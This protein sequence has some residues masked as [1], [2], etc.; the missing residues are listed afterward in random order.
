MV[1]KLKPCPFCGSDFLISQEPRDN[2]PVE[3]KFYIYHKYGELG[4]A[5][6]ECRLSVNG[7]FDSEQDAAEFWNTR[8]D[9]AIQ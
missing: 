4:S 5:A 2:Y 6:R 3:G 9:E 1:V 8:S 7:H